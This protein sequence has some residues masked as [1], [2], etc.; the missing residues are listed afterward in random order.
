MVAL[1][2]R[3]AWQ[4]PTE[5]SP[6]YSQNQ[7]PKPVSLRLPL[8]SAVGFSTT[9]T[10]TP[11]WHLGVAADY[12]PDDDGF[13]ESQAHWYEVTARFSGLRWRYPAVCRQ[14]VAT[15][16]T[17]DPVGGRNGPVSVDDG[18]SPEKPELGE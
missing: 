18:R 11:D 2:D 5:P 15:D 17:C 8:E 7:T 9:T 10:G 16:G 6:S 3:L 1:A 12:P 14:A 13:C 4:T